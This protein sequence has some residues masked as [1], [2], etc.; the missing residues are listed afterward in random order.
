M[1]NLLLLAHDDEG[2]EARLQ[3]A[4]DLTRR[5]NGHL[6][7]LDVIV[8]PPAIVDDSVGTSIANTLL[9]DEIDRE[10]ANR[11]RTEARLA[12]EDISW[13]WREATGELA[14]CLRSA[15]QF[16][17]L[18]VVNKQ[19]EDYP[20]T[21]MLGVASEVIVT[22][23]KPVLAVPQHVARYD[24][25]CAVVAWNGSDSATRALRAAIPLLKIAERVFLVEVADDDDKG[26]DDGDNSAEEAARYLSR[27]GIHARIERVAPLPS[28][29]GRT[30]IDEAGRHGA[31]LVV[32]GGYG[33]SRLREALFGGVTRELLTHSPYPLL[34]SH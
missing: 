27:H 3:V 14:S 15:S 20:Y 2:Q 16:A 25:G 8:P 6:T 21:N 5:F 11:T 19:L 24:G 29:I 17:D 31:G 13:D 22:S 7:C 28:G 10:T 30:L 26:D 32:V 12:H 4:I 1:K 33:H 34:L 9:A 18:I 23:E